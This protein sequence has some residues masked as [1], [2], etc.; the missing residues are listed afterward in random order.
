MLLS[1][2]GAYLIII[3]HVLF[4]CPETFDELKTWVIFALSTIIVNCVLLLE[5]FLSREK[6]YN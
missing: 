2:P 3:S 5:Y 6:E 4:W 1:A